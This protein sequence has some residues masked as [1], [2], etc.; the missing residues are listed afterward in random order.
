MINVCDVKKQPEL[1]CHSK[2]IICHP[3]VIHRVALLMKVSQKD[4]KSLCGHNLTLIND[5]TANVQ[6]DTDLVCN[7][8]V[9]PTVSTS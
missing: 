2:Y 1:N 6:C 8:I 4:R 9:G 7:T 3:C 5:K